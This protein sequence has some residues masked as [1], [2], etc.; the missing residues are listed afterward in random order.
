MISRDQLAAILPLAGRR[1]DAFVS[2][3]N[4]AMREW[5][6]STPERQAAFLAQ[7]GHESGSLVYLREL[8]S[9]AAYEGRADLGN[10]RPGDG[11]RF[12]GRGPIQIT[13]RDNYG[14]CSLALF[15]D[16]RLLQFPEML[17]DPAIGCRAAG[18]FWHAH[19]L[20]DLADDGNF[21]RITK[22]INGGYTH[23]DER[24]ALFNTASAVLNPE[25]AQ[26][27]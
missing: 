9:G 1:L 7:V 23:Y 13:G 20:N 3:L 11:V 25:G 14:A 27:A 6:I 12:K 15:R 16:D 4:A 21:R 10:T 19:G 24:L 2:P 26:N 5:F 8:A 18:W 17:E 22:I